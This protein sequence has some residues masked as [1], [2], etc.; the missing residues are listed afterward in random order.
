M[1][2][3]KRK[4]INALLFIP[5]IALISWSAF[6]V[7]QKKT[8]PHLSTIGEFPNSI[9]DA[10]GNKIKKADLL[11]KYIFLEF[12]DKDSPPLNE[13]LTRRE[14]EPRLAFLLVYD[15]NQETAE[16]LSS[17]SIIYT[18]GDSAA[19]FRKI[20]KGFFYLYNDKGVPIEYGRSGFGYEKI[21]IVLMNY[22]QNDKFSPTDLIDNST[23]I[24]DLVQE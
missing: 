11:G 5:G 15:S 2:S 17:N 16:K 24:L 18:I 22:L 4:L 1:E 9:V 23:W 21:K 13:L 20:K 10:S 14:K 6:S 3:R 19:Y 8:S 12:R 7:A